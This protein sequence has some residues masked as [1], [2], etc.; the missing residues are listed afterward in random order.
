MDW[1]AGKY[2]PICWFGNLCP[3]ACTGC[4][5]S[6]GLYHGT[7]QRHAIDT[8]ND[9]IATERLMRQSVST[10]SSHVVRQRTNDDHDDTEL[11]VRPL[12]LPT[13]NVANIAC[14][15]PGGRLGLWTWAKRGT[16]QWHA[17]WL[18]GMAVVSDLPYVDVDVEAWQVL[19][20]AAR[21]QIVGAC[22]TGAL[23]RVDPGTSSATAM[24][25]IA[26]GRRRPFDDTD[27]VVTPRRHCADLLFDPAQCTTCNQCQRASRQVNAERPAVRVPLGFG[28]GHDRGHAPERG[29]VMRFHDHHKLPV[30][31]IAQGGAFLLKRQWVAL[32]DIMRPSRFATLIQP[33]VD[34][35]LSV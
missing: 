13:P 8:G 28:L 19:D 34:E 7:W 20:D 29:L 15:P 31:D 14:L 32:F 26:D 24:S 17:R 3:V 25:D 12:P 22:P 18:P 21:Q 1:A 35:V 27:H 23:Q 33:E 10:D 16:A 30:G 9:V 5:Y 11:M 6:V 2:T 4:G